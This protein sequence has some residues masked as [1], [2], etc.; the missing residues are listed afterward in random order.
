MA[1]GIVNKTNIATETVSKLIVKAI[2]TDSFDDEAIDV[3]NRES[4]KGH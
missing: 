3:L 2:F 4:V 1:L